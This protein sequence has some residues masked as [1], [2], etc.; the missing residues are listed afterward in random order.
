MIDVESVHSTCNNAGLKAADVFGE[1]EEFSWYD[2]C[3]AIG[4]FGAAIILIV[5]TAPLIVLA[6]I[7]VK[8]TSRGSAIYSQTRLG[9]WG[10]PF[11]IYKIRTMVSDSEKMGAQWCTVGDPRITPLGQFLR[12]THL[13][14]LPHSGTSSAGR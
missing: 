5:L 12:R 6:M 1:P 13:D 8:L 2:S 3:K 14:E 9:R 4:D 11:T 7:L 10:R